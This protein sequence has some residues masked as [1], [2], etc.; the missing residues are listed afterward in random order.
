MA[1]Q[2]LKLLLAFASVYVIWGSTYLTIRWAIETIPPFTM[3]GVRYATAGAILVAAARW[4]GAAWPTATQ[5]RSA[6]VV[7]VLLLTGGNGG[8]TWSELRV[9]SGLAALVVA[10][11][12][13][14]IVLMDWIRPSGVHPGRAAIMGIVLGLVGVGL[15]VNPAASDT[16]RIDP[17][18]TAALIVATVCWAAGSI[19]SRHAPVAQPLMNAGANMLCGGA[20][21]L[22][23]GAIMREPQH[24][25]WQAVS[26][27][28]LL[29]LAYLVVFGAVV[30]F[31]AYVWLLRHTTPAR[32]ATYAYVNPVVAVFLGWLLANEPIT[33][34]VLAAAAVIIAAVVTITAGPAVRIWMRRRTEAVIGDA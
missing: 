24:F 6:A 18:G 4:R 26:A 12:P 2:R 3:A 19:Y 16:A 15:L 17:V 32:A 27:K 20:G 25:A 30:G 8:V 9:P 34:R 10:A 29:S 13:M 22:T 31:T 7:G 23:L 33:P 11:V 21:L 14:W 5:W 1:Q 28:S